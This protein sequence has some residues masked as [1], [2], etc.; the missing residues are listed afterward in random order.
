MVRSVLPIVGLV[1]ASCITVT[2]VTVAQKTSLE[3]QLIGDFEPLTEEELLAASVRAAPDVRAGVMGELQ[4][5]AISARR[6]Q[7]FN[8][9][10][11]DAL[12]DAGCVGESDSAE[13][14]AHPCEGEGDLVQMGLR[15]RL[16]AEE[17]AD[18]VAI[19]DWAVAIDPA[20]TAADRPQVAGLYRNLLRA[21]LRAGHWFLQGG[22]WQQ[23]AT[24]AQ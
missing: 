8:R 4:Q 15:G 9:D 13:L 6:R 5:R 19:I 16:L 24:R 17:N 18:R 1:S 14:L 3:R 21:A 22:Q 10:D 7:L 20:L 23:V 11:I 12:R 2:T